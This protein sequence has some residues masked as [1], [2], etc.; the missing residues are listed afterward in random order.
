MAKKQTQARRI[1]D[2]IEAAT[3]HVLC[4]HRKF[5]DSDAQE[6]HMLRQAICY[7]IGWTQEDEP[8]VSQALEKLLEEVEG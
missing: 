6:L 8:E 3:M 5:I 1:A 4:G 7:L 2:G